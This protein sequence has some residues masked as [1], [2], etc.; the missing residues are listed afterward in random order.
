MAPQAL[1]VLYDPDPAY[2]AAAVVASLPP[3]V[4]AEDL[5][6]LEPQL[7]SL[8]QNGSAIERWYGLQGFREPNFKS[9]F[10]QTGKLLVRKCAAIAHALRRVG[11]GCSLLVWADTDVEFKRPL[12]AAFV[13]WASQHEFA[14]TPLPGNGFHK[15]QW[16]QPDRA[17]PR[18]PDYPRHDHWIIE[19]GFMSFVPNR[20]TRALASAA[21]ELYEGGLLA[22]A[23]HCGMIDGD[24]RLRIPFRGNRA[25]PLRVARNLFIN[26]VFVWS[27]LARLAEGQFA[28]P[29]GFAC[30]LC[31]GRNLTQGWF[32]FVDRLA[33]ARPGHPRVSPFSLQPHYVVHHTFN[34]GAFNM[35]YHS[36]KQHFQASLKASAMRNV[37]CTA[38]NASKC[39]D[40]TLLGTTFNPYTPSA[41]PRLLAANIDRA[42]WRDQP[43]D[44]SELGMP[45]AP[46]V[47]T[48]GCTHESHP[49]A[50]RTLSCQYRRRDK[51]AC[52]T[53]E[54][55]I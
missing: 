28:A 34:D 19:S 20:C 22:L 33:P 52:T 12:D 27:L 23:A 1:F 29:R 10:L 14:Y 9:S 47:A 13:A 48:C 53:E 55:R 49:D 21:V 35:R 45:L 32:A 51:P 18:D 43:W 37:T 36:S 5:F 44:L 15:R 26:D 54:E 17:L 7:E 25:C 3:S 30:C 39:T 24:S 42:H 11:P 38:D 4:L 40:L 2:D 50:A 16:N 46:R 6:A 31:A 8:M 41:D